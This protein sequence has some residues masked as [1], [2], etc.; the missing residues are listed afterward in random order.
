[1]KKLLMLSFLVAISL[2]VQAQVNV[3]KV[4]KK[5][6]KHYVKVLK[7]DKAQ[8]VEIQNIIVQKYNN[9]EAIASLK[10]EDQALFRAKRRALFAGM[11]GSIRL[12]LNREQ[13]ELFDIEKRRQRLVNADKIQQL[14]AS[15]ADQEDIMDAQFGIYKD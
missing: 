8:K 15:G 6:A 5:E 14:Q 12:M 13:I 2:S 1:M 3:D 7:L 4:A 11:D 10:N 9:L